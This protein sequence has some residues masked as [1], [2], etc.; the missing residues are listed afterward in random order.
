MT[1]RDSSECPATGKRRW[2]TRPK[3]VT[4][5][6]LIQE[7]SRR[8]RVPQRVYFCKMCNGWHLTHEAKHRNK[9]DLEND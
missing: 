4:E 7:R 1:L 9:K 6:R 8:G 2:G 5:L 3:A